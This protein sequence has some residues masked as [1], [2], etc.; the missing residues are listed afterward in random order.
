MEEK[1]K[2]VAELLKMMA[3]EYRM[4]ILCAL[5]EETLTVSQIHEFVPGITASA[6]SQHLSQLKR[7]G[8]LESQKQGLNVYYKIADKRVLELLAVLKEQYCS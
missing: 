1:A 8:I 5:T 3:N 7:G 4:L 2:I 6:L